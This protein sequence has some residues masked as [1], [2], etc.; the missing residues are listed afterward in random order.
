MFGHLDCPWQIPES[1][2]VSSGNPQHAGTAKPLQYAYEFRRETSGF[3]FSRKI[4]E[5]TVS[6]QIDIGLKDFSV[7]V[8]EL[9]A[10]IFSTAFVCILRQDDD[11]ASLNVIRSIAEPA[12]K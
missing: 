7:S 2:R 6:G 9:K 12:A 1:A 3:H 10:S 5:W 8:A 4:A 11:L